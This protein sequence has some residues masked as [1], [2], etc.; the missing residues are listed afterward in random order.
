[1]QDAPPAPHSRKAGEA[2]GTGRASAERQA[3]GSAPPEPTG[4]EP[5]RIARHPS[6]ATLRAGLCPSPWTDRQKGSRAQTRP[7]G[8]AKPHRR[9]GGAA[10]SA[11]PK[12]K[13]RPR[14]PPH[15][16]RKRLRVGRATPGGVLPRLPAL[17]RRGPVPCE[18]AGHLHRASPSLLRET[19]WHEPST[20]RPHGRD[21]CPPDRH[22]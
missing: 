16:R 19:I 22:D 3:R 12:R 5:E 20:Q 14:R 18:D 15:A 13:R 4:P 2:R 6:R 8:T 9:N 10:P 1:M 7:S 21:L 11:R 17:S